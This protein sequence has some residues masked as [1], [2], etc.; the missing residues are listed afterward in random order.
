MTYE[1]REISMQLGEPLELYE[2]K[3][4]DEILRFT[5]A[6]STVEYLG[7]EWEPTLIKRAG[8]EYTTDNGRNNLKLT[9]TRDFA[10]AELFRVMPP[11]TVVLLTVHRVHAADGDGAV[12]WAGRVLECDWSGST[13]TLNCEPVSTSMQRNGLRRMYQ[14]ACPHV[15]YG[16]QCKVIKEEF[17]F[18]TD[19]EFI[20]GLAFSTLALESF[21]SGYFS[22][23]YFEVLI[24]GHLERRFITE[25][26]FTLIKFNA[27]L[28]GLNVGA[29]ITLYAGCDHTLTTCK[30]KFDNTDNYGGM[31]FIPRKNPFNGSIY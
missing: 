25:H 13:A 1:S 19:I 4:N 29:T 26:V 9:V 18:I 2:F 6:R 15:L 11:S 28:P 16:G 14:R 17:S 5:S 22:G 12:V 3:H 7:H 27:P 24:E 20:S 21:D 30:D 31:P 8:I 10:I 23:G